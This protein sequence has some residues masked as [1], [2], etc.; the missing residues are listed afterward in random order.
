MQYLVLGG[1]LILFLVF[2]KKI[3]NRTQEK[4]D[5]NS[6]LRKKYRAL[7]LYIFSQAWHETGGFKS[8]LALEQNNLFGMKIPQVRE[9]VGD[10]SNPPYMTYRSWSESV[11]DLLLWFE[12]QR[13][14]TSV[15]SPFH[16][17]MSLR[18][19]GYFTD[20]VDNYL[21]GM[22]NGLKEYQK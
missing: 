17:T 9:F 11:D 6:G 4:Q 12:N 19:R 3:G 14:P 7:L 2:R 1:L 21:R 16:Y 8:R 18:Q 5:W 20:S 15:E 22:L 13:F 10:K